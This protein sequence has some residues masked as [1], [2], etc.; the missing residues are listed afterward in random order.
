MRV[1]LTTVLLSL[2]FYSQQV[3]AIDPGLNWKTIESE[4][5][6][7]HYAEGHKAYAEHAMAIRS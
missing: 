5:L 7:V 2:G 6:F 1:L 4:N 3:F